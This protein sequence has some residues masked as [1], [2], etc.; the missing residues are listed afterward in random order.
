MTETARLRLPI[1]AAAQ[2]QKHVTHN[3]AL[4]ALDTLVQAAVLD[5][6][7]T[8]PPGSPAEGDCYIVAGA[9]GAATGA[10]EGFEKRIA[11][12]QDGQW[13]SFLPGA[14]SGEGW[15]AY[16]MD[17]DALYRFDGTNWG[18]AGIEGPEG[19]QGPPG[20]DGQGI[21]P[22]ATG[23]LAER[24]AYDGAAQ[25]FVYLRTDV[26]PFELYVKASGASGDWAGPSPIAG[27][28]R[29]TLSGNRTYY[30]RTDGNDGNNGLTD[31]AGGAFA[32]LQKAFNTIATLDLNGF[33]VTVQVKDGTYT[34]GVNM[35]K[36]WV[37]GNIVFQGNA[38]TPGN[39][40]ISTTSA[41][42]FQ[43]G[44][45]P[46]GSVL[47]KDMELRTTTSGYGLIV[48]VPGRLDFQNLR[49]GACAQD[50]TIASGSG[51]QIV[52]TGDYAIVGG[53]PRHMNALGGGSIA[54]TTRT[55]TLTGTPAFSAA[56]AVASRVGSINGHSNTYSGSATGKRY[57]VVLNAVINTNGGGA[58]YFPGNSAGTTA[59][60]GQYA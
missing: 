28:G 21:E 27:G 44:V 1:L 13:I 34:A 46:G 8:A 3:E 53:A 32:T 16:V 31:S 42:C 5:K 43:L 56:F 11:R 24:A 15:L 35:D 4:T 40:V 58:S 30:V 60:G 51:S 9:G 29:E 37:G 59:T 55:V 12:F 23:T 22:D 14:G 45:A 54:V 48:T 20:A 33:T 10:W 49:F 52:C 50:H 19:P 41:N 39:V 57:D 7:L 38:T 6:D 25:G 2:A 36:P 47:V 17:E 26:T 18:L